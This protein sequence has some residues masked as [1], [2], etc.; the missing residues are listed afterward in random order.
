MKEQGLTWKEDV[1]AYCAYC[2]T[3]TFQELFSDDNVKV[4]ICKTCNMEA[5]QLILF[6]ED[7]K[8]SMTKHF[9]KLRTGY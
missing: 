7:T 4:F 8:E 5:A 9:N 1:A 6:P 3:I 2:D